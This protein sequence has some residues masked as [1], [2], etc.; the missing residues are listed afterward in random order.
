MKFVL[1]CLLF[2]LA[3]LLTTTWFYGWPHTEFILLRQRAYCWLC[4]DSE[5]DHCSDPI[6]LDPGFIEPCRA[7]RAQI[8]ALYTLA[9][10][11]E[12]ALSIIPGYVYDNVGVRRCGGIGV[13]LF[14]MG[15][16]LLS[17]SSQ[18]WPLYIPAF[19]LFGHGINYVALACVSLS[20]FAKD[21]EYLTM[22][23]AMM[24]QQ[25]ATII[26]PLLWNAIQ[27][28]PSVSPSVILDFYWV[29]LALPL[30]LAM[31][32]NLPSRRRVPKISF[33]GVLELQE[34]EP[35]W[36]G[37]YREACK[38]EFIVYV[39]WYATT[40]MGVNTVMTNMVANMGTAVSSYYGWISWLPLGPLMGLLNEY[41]HSIW[42]L[43]AITIAKVFIFAAFIVN[44]PS[45]NYFVVTLQMVEIGYVHALKI[46]FINENFER[47]H[48]GKLSGVA[49][50]VSGLLQ[51]LN[52]YVEGSNVP[53]RS[54]FGFWLTFTAVQCLMLAYLTRSHF[55]EQVKTNS[56]VYFS[57][58]D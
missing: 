43:W 57:I 15:W 55:K 13:A 40:N 52:I 56:S 20:E 33:C 29:G 23:V 9:T 8:Q 34:S 27:A 28:N 41:I 45:Y 10:S 53:I 46:Y 6:P 7:Q 32:V 24:A 30:G 1:R 49:S 4:D 12:Y 51:L 21:W 44:S 38:P 16:S 36:S 58:R 35:Q 14:A 18:A 17:M 22:S 48:L 25:V 37:F 42:S 50:L 5:I 3:T 2:G 54:E 31:V 19:F 47:E 11:V 39:A 26:P